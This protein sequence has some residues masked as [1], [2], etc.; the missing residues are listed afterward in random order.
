MFGAA[1]AYGNIDVGMFGRRKQEI[2]TEKF[3]FL[4]KYFT[5]TNA[6]HRAVNLLSAGPIP[7]PRAASLH[8]AVPM[9][10]VCSLVPTFAIPSMWVS[11]GPRIGAEPGRQEMS[12]KKQTA[13]P[14]LPLKIL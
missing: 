1:C 10:S 2:I 5:G 14:S 3:C 8:L 9:G 12:N 4:L 11:L 13:P 7:A 6:A